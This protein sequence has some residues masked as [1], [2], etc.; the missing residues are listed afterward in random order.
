M[1]RWLGGGGS[2]VDGDIISVGVQSRS[3]ERSDVILLG[4]ASET[5][6]RIVA[7]PRGEDG[8]FLRGADVPLWTGPRGDAVPAMAIADLDDDGY[9][10]I[11]ALVGPDPGALIVWGDRGRQGSV[12]AVPV[13]MEDLRSITSADLDGDGMPE[14]IVASAAQVALIT[15][16]GREPTP[17]ELVRG[18]S[19]TD[20]VLVADL[21]GDGRA[22]LLAQHDGLLDIIL[23]A[24]GNQAA[25]KLEL[26]P[27][28]SQMRAA[29]LDGDQI[30][31]LVGIRDG[32][33]VTRRS[34]GGVLPP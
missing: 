18:F 21:E 14:L 24:P 23:R 15:F 2:I 5:E 25:L 3:D 27:A 20:G 9:D 26:T 8:A 10:D 22:D 30:L 13:T 19:T 16:Q 4:Q 6:L 33:V 12:S 7:L 11:A 29:D 17:P 32:G 34:N 28:W 31:D 1:L